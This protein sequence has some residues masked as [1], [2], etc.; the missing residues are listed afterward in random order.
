MGTTMKSFTEYLTESTKTYSFKLKVAGDLCDDVQQKLSDALQKF[1]VVNLSKGKSTPIREVA[2][3][4][5]E[6]ENVGVTVWEVEIRYPTTQKVLEEYIAS[7]INTPLHCVKVRNLNEPL[8]QYQENMTDETRE[9]LNKPEL[10]DVNGQELVGQ[11]RATGL[12]K[13]IVNAKYEQYKGVNDDLL[14]NSLPE[15]KAAE[16]LEDQASKSPLGSTQN[17]L[18]EAHTAAGLK[19]K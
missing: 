3:D 4:F 6:L 1:S 14:A 12:L 5:P 9:V 10:E 17:K 15:E 8:E 19:G 2:L 13:D 18:P 16:K 11:K 7:A